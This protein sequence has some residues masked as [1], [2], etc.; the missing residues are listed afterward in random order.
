VF[1]TRPHDSSF[2][3]Y[4]ESLGG[5]FLGADRRSKGLIERACMSRLSR[6]SNQTVCDELMVV[7]W[8]SETCGYRVIA[9]VI[10]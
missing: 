10:S 6:L 7:E 8:V 9:P 1:G 2:Q 4:S 3:C 5:S